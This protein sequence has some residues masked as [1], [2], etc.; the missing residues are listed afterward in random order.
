MLESCLY[1][2]DLLEPKYGYLKKSSKSKDFGTFFSWKSCV[3][4][5]LD[6]FL[7]PS[8]K[9]LPQ[10]NIADKKFSTYSQRMY[11]IALST[12]TKEIS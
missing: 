5:S 10:Q 12:Y 11:I 4:V 3:Q 1:F 2:G 6:L 8:G 7:L 9:N